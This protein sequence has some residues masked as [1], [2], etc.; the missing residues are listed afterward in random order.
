MS[1]EDSMRP[2][3][4]V[5]DRRFWQREDEPPREEPPR[6]EIDVERLR[7]ALAELEDAKIRIRRDAERERDRFKGE[8]LE[9]LLP[10]LDNL[11]RSLAVDPAA[12]PTSAV[13]DGVKLVHGQLLGALGGFGLER[14]SAVGQRFDPRVHDAVAVIPVA[15]PMQDGVVVA[16][17]EPAYMFGDRVV[18]PA[19]VSVGRAASRSTS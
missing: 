18:R 19:R 6:P 16:E 3:F 13:L 7:T 11:E 1:N 17:L 8:V 2:G 10:V 5:R 15:D 4:V 14:R 12:T 9:Q